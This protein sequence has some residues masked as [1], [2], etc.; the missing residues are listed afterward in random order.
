VTGAPSFPINNS[1]RKAVADW[2]AQK[3]AERYG[4]QLQ[5]LQATLADAEKARQEQQARLEYSDQSGN[6]LP[7]ITMQPTQVPS[8]IYRTV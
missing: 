7:V 2:Y 1:I 8:G 3:M 5:Q 6:K 4:G